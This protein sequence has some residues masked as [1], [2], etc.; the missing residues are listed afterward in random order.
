MVWS[1][2]L[3]LN[4]LSLVRL[5]RTLSKTSL[6]E[7]Q[8]S[9]RDLDTLSPNRGKVVGS[10]PVEELECFQSACA[11]LPVWNIGLNDDPLY[12]YF[13]FAL[14]QSARMDDG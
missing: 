13:T 5:W 8:R 1:V 4:I 11:P 2:G 10:I 14:V 7:L 3:Q 12:T 6:H 9:R